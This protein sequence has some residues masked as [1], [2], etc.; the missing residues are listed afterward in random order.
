M[1]DPF[2]FGVG[3]A[4]ADSYLDEES[5]DRLADCPSCGK[6]QKVKEN[7]VFECRHCGE[8]FRVR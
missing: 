1:F 4:I 3:A 5:K 8:E 7:T 6:A 2:W